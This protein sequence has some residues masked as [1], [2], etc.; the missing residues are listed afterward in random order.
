MVDTQFQAGQYQLVS[1][2]L[3]NYTRESKIEISGLI[4]GFTIN[5]SMS[6]PF[7]HGKTT[8]FDGLD[9]MST[10]P[11]IGEEFIEFTYID[12]FGKTRVDEFIVYS[13]SDVKYPQE[14]N[15]TL[16]QYT[17]NFVSIPR[18]LTDGYRIM[19]GYRDGKISDYAKL[20]YNEYFKDQ[21][22]RRNL[23]S[24][25]FVAQLTDNNQHLVVPN[26]TPI[27]TMLFFARHAF[28]ND[29][30]TQTFRFFENRDKYFF[31][32]NEYIK[33]YYGNLSTGVQNY[34]NQLSELTLPDTHIF[35]YNYLPNITPQAQ[36][37][38]MFNI[39][40][41]DFG[42]KVNT[43]NDI[44]YGAYK[45]KICQ[46]DLLNGTAQIIPTYSIQQDF[47]RN[48]KNEK[49]AHSIGFIN[50]VIP[51]KYIRYIIKDYAVGGEPTG[52]EI[53]PDMKYSDL[54][55]RKSSYLYHY[56]QNS[57][58]I[59]I[60]GRN[61]IVAGSVINLQLPIRKVISQ[62]SASEIDTER[63]GYYLADSVQNIF[64]NKT[65]TQ[66]ITLSRYGIGT[67]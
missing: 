1:A 26:F 22:E 60:Y 23:K 24:K 66:K 10:L 37:M 40:N 6:A 59:T 44:K 14:S 5:E 47:S 17:L 38:Q 21:L 33:S 7:L 11:V 25:S 48:T 63:S 31:A 67:R 30:H 41:I 4:T 29:S 13:V 52:P 34:L 46:I 50:D 57:I 16:L 56:K 35:N 39:L 8:V 15:P 18:V 36:K 55:D 65:Y 51:D 28:N 58:D 2:Y 62:N 53:K 61:D 54:Y 3:K 43:I 32:T 20:V 19:K 12:F 64:N 9:I 27:E 42:E 45:K 49:L